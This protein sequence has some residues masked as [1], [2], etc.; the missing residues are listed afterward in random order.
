MNVSYHA[1]EILPFALLACALQAC[2]GGDSGEASTHTHAGIAIGGDDSVASAS[3]PASKF[4]VS[5]AA[6]SAPKIAGKPATAV[7]QG[8]LYSFQP[9]AADADGNALKF[10][11]VN[12]PVW[13]TFDAQ[14]GLLQGTPGPGDVGKVAGIVINVSDGA[15][16]A[17]LRAFN[18]SVQPTATGW[19]RLTWD[20]PAARANGAP[21]KNLAGFKVYWGTKPGRYSNSA[22]IMN[23]DVTAYVVENLE[24][25]TYHFRVAALN[26]TGAERVYSNLPSKTIP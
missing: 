5:P 17:A 21:L 10:S 26:S 6:N 4:A 19:A 2:G 22:T 1:F 16:H 20:P 14:T 3:L 11:I 13:A 9:T 23:P 12:R 25:N 18:L 8:T 15:A 7:P 24:P